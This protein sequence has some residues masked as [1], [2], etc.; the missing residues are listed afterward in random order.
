[1]PPHAHLRVNKQAPATHSSQ[2]PCSVQLRSGTS[3]HQAPVRLGFSDK[4]SAPHLGFRDKP[5]AP[6]SALQT[7]DLRH[8]SVLF[9]SLSR[10]PLSPLPLL[11]LLLS[12][13]VVPAAAAAAA[14]PGAAPA[15]VVVAAG[16]AGAVSLGGSSCCCCCCCSCCRRSGC[17]R[18]WCCDGRGACSAAGG[19]GGL[20]GRPVACRGVCGS[21]RGLYTG[22]STGCCCWRQGR[23]HGHEGIAL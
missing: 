22:L 1:M 18:C 19:N 13:L 7:E 17:G 16:A 3:K 2:M 11:L 21:G 14:A 15:A 8:C 20:G 4:L 12:Y 23:G 5:S 10:S 9:C 6:H